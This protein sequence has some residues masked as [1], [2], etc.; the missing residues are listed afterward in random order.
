MKPL[1]QKRIEMQQLSTPPTFSTTFESWFTPRTQQA[2]RGQALRIATT[3]MLVGFVAGYIAIFVLAQPLGL[4]VATGCFGFALFPGWVC[5]TQKSSL[6][7]GDQWFVLGSTLWIAVIGTGPAYGGSVR[8]I[9]SG[10]L[11]ITMVAMAAL[12][13]VVLWRQFSNRWHPKAHH[14]RSMVAF[15][16]QI[17]RTTKH[18]GMK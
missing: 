5:T 3:T 1:L 10:L 8:L 9:S 2:Q 18:G 6:S 7:I 12:Y 14:Q 15:D 17:I 13:A 16:P 4:L 11:I